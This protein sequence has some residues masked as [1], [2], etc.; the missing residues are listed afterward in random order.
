MLKKLTKY[1]NSTTL[2]IDKAILALLN[3][4]ESSVVKLQTDGKS[5][6]ITP[7]S[8]I[9]KEKT[10][11]GPMEAMGT[12]IKAV[13]AKHPKREVSLD[14]MAEMKDAFAK[15][16][17]KHS[18]VMAT[19]SQHFVSNQEFQNAVVALAEKYDPV[20]QP[21][22][23]LKEFMELRRQFFPEVTELDKEIAAIGEKYKNS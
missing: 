18:K 11:H 14:T 19:F 6:I 20:D 4:N 1:G 2:V 10:S 13:E 21:E 15:V 3:M 9:N 7:V 16:F 5:L 17:A 22:E 23:Y 8:S 12:A